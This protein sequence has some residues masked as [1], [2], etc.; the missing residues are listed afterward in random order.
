MREVFRIIYAAQKA[1]IEVSISMGNGAA[2]SHLGLPR[3]VVV[4]SEASG[5]VGGAEMDHDHDSI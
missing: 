1:T 2:D 4:P 5:Y 3:E